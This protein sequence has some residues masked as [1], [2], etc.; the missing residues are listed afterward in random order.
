MSRQPVPV[1]LLHVFDAQ[2]Y[3]CVCGAWCFGTQPCEV[4]VELAAVLLEERRAHR[5]ARAEGKAGICLP[6]CLPTCL[7]SQ[8]PGP[9]RVRE[10]RLAG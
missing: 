7:P 1:Q 5:A 9:G 2:I 10:V 8:S 6:I 3:R 4:C